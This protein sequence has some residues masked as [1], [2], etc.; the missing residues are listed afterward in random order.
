MQVKPWRRSI[1]ILTLARLSCVRN[2][3]SHSAVHVFTFVALTS[4]NASNRL[5]LTPTHVVM[6]LHA[7]IGQN[8][9]RQV[10]NVRQLI[11]S[12]A[13]DTGTVQAAIRGTEITPRS[14]LPGRFMHTCGAADETTA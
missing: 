6:T 10:T 7:T 8:A 11:S 14:L 3:D 4:S 12:L 1:D 13:C 2:T 5:R 9:Q